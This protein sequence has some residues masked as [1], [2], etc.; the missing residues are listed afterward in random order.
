MYMVRTTR[1]C[2]TLQVKQ[3]KYMLCI[4]KRGIVKGQCCSLVSNQREF[5]LFDS[6]AL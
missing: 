1:W 6:N 3:P 5:S 4:P 2:S